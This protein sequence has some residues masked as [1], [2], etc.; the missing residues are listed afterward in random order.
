[1]LTV[2]KQYEASR[3]R[4]RVLPYLSNM[5]RAGAILSA[6]SL[7][8]HIFGHSPINITIFGKKS[9]KQNMRVRFSLQHFL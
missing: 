8:T 3:E 7:A 2:C 1:M 9:I 5:P 4:G 6:F